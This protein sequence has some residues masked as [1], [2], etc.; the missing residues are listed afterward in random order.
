MVNGK[1]RTWTDLRIKQWSRHGHLDL[2]KEEKTFP[3][4]LGIVKEG[5]TSIGSRLKCIV[6]CF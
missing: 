2:E 3:E 1:G 4:M 5:M 6:L